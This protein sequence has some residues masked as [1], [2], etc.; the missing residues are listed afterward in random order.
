MLTIKKSFVQDY[1]K[2]KDD[3]IHFIEKYVKITTL[4]YGMQPFLLYPYQRKII[5][6][7]KN[8][9]FVLILQARQSGKTALISAY[10]LWKAIFNPNTAHCIVANKHDAAK[11]IMYR[12]KSI[13]ENFND[14]NLMLKDEN[15]WSKTEIGFTNGSYIL[16]CATSS[17]SARGLTLN[18]LYIDE[19]SFI[20]QNGNIDEG[21]LQ[22][23]M[24]TISSGKTSQFI[25]TSS[26]GS[27]DGFFYNLYQ[28]SLKGENEFKVIE[29]KWIDVP[30]YRE[31]PFFEEN[32]ISKIGRGQFMQEF[33]NDFSSN[34]NINEVLYFNNTKITQMKKNDFMEDDI[35]SNFYHSEK[36]FENCSYCGALDISEGIG[37]D[38][39]VLSIFRYD[40]LDKKYHLVGYYRSNDIQPFTLC[41]TVNDIVNLYNLKTIVIE[42]NGVGSAVIETLIENYG[43][44]NIYKEEGQKM[45]GIS[46]KMQTKSIGMASAKEYIEN[47]DK[48]IVTSHIFLNELI[49]YTNKGRAK[50]GF[51]D[52]VSTLILL[53][54]AIQTKEL[55]PLLEYNSEQEV[56]ILDLIIIENY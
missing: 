31:D 39:T 22:S 19:A 24:P 56:D 9:R 43:I 35:I 11:S 21:F 15:R 42:R 48:I 18:S 10:L 41:S 45:H 6:T 54:Y 14:E 17:N 8:N 52:T 53:A 20:G 16:S 32:M 3:P 25:L 23:V 55:D 2:C 49:F 28:G 29:V 27:K 50:R 51:D 40:S 13:Y 30:S 4:D 34:T 33:N 1:I 44:T 12:I 36:Y 46:I 26:A 37:K 7:L 47:T 5:E 38:F